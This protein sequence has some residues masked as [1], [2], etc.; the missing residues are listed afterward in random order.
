MAF[1]PQMDGLFERKNQW[2]EQFLRLV[3]EG[4]QDDWSEWL[5]L[6]KAVHNGRIN[7]TIKIAPTQALLGYFPLLDPLA[8]PL[9]TNPRMEERAK[10][11]AKFHQLT[12]EALN[13]AVNWTPPDQFKVGT[14]VWLEG[15]NLALPYQTCKLTPKHHGP[16]IITKQVSPVMYQ[17]QIPPT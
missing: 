4:W 10:Q 8:P 16:F 1:H 6:V 17:L 2:V 12:Q 9:T 14:K 3:V 11:A 5:P 7:T 13:K 15:S